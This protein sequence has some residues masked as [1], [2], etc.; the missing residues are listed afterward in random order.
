MVK[1]FK[2]ISSLLS[3]IQ[4]QVN[5]TM[6]NE[7]ASEVQFEEQRQIQKHVYESYDPF[8]YDR[9]GFSNGGLQD[10]DMIVAVTE[11]RKDSVVLSVV[12]MAT[13]K[14]D[15]NLYLAPLIE[16]GHDIGFGEYEYP[17]NRDHTAWKFLQSRPFTAETIEALKKSGKHVKALR[18][19]LIRR[20][21]N[22]K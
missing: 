1:Q 5:S 13:G 6:K 18:D 2:D 4:K 16:H 3:H 12:N 8:V 17:Y 20:G 22:V 7:V 10:I 11:I 21:I 19:G 9:R 14:D 15:E